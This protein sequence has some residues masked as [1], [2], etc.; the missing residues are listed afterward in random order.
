MTN[1]QN[2]GATKV[3]SFNPSLLRTESK[4]EFEKLIDE[5]KRYVQPTNFVESMYAY[6]V[7]VL[8]WEIMR[9]R[10]NKAGIINNAL[11]AALEKFL[12]RFLLPPGA[13]FTLWI[14][15]VL[16]ADRLAYD[17]F[18]SQEAKDRFSGLLEEAGFDMGAVEAEAVRQSLADIEKVERL[19]ASA[20]LRRDKYLGSIAR[21]HER[22]AR[23][24]EENS[25]RL[26]TADSVPSVTSSDS[27]N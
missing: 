8:T 1:S 10:R 2:E 20:E 21:S 13:N 3:F 12:Q 17:W 15:K 18:Y 19:I 11:R 9:Y 22:L 24:L 16:S 7:A 23:K 14:E 4:E 25:D 26:L 6:E 5:L 27:V